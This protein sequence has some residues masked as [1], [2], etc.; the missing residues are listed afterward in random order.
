MANDAGARRFAVSH[1]ES[2]S[3]WPADRHVPGEQFCLLLLIEHSTVD[4]DTVQQFAFQAIS[5]GLVYLCV[6]GP[7]SVWFEQVVDQVYEAGVEGREFTSPL[8][9]TAHRDL[10]E[11]FL[12]FEN[13]ATPDNCDL[14]WIVSVG[15]VSQA[16]ATMHEFALRHPVTTI[17]R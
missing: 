14:W 6:W 13:D 8:V 11:A 7:D 4:I 5:Q 9:T 17:A 1:L 12:F 16:D 10:Q 2:L 15:E 3:A